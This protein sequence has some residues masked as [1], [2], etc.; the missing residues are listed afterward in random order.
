MTTTERLIREFQENH[1]YT[2]DDQFK[3][4]IEEIGELSEAM[5]QN[6]GK[7]IGK[8]NSMNED[9]IFEEIGDCMFTLASIAQLYDIRWRVAFNQTAEENLEK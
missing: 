5:L 6:E 9:N 7:K 1:E 4:L 2:I 3:V 8:I